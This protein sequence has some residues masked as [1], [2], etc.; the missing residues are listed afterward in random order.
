MIFRIQ[1]EGQFE[2]PADQLVEINLLDDAVEQALD[3][4][5]AGFTVALNALLDKVRTVGAELA[6]DVL[7]ES[8]VILPAS[9]ATAAEVR[10]L[11]GSQGLVPD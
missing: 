6:D 2:V 3:G 7:V 1:G 8:D 10:E 9:E 4:D 11:L 5:E